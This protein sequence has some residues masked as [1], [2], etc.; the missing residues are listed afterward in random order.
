MIVGLVL[1]SGFALNG[2]GLKADSVYA[3]TSLSD[4]KK[5]AQLTV[6]SAYSK[7][8]IDRSDLKRAIKKI[9]AALSK[10]NVPTLYRKNL[11]EKKNSLENIEYHLALYE[12]NLDSITI[13]IDKAK[14]VTRVNELK[15]TVTGYIKNLKSYAIYIDDCNYYAQMVLDSNGL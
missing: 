11:K 10:K 5:D 15:S 7:V 1:G 6:T 3:A 12:G 8:F 9:D 4:A 2:T 14:T 13:E